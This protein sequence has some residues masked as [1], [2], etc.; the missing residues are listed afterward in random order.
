V[1]TPITMPELT[2]APQGAA[3]ATQPVPA[4][5][6]SVARF[7]QL[8][9]APSANVQPAAGGLLAAAVGENRL[10]VHLQRLSERWEAGQ[11]TLQKFTGNAEFTTK[12]LIQ[13]QMQ[14]ISCALDVELSAKCA[15][16]FENGVQTLTQRS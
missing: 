1:T 16:I 13:T 14:M 10:Q 8:M 5:P 12:D 2:F 9:Y 11:V 15:G 3:N 7:E 6:D 4:A